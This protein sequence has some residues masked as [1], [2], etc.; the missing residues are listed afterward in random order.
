MLDAEDVGRRML[1]DCTGQAVK[2]VAEDMADSIAEDSAFVLRTN[3]S[4]VEKE[5]RSVHPVSIDLHMEE[6]GEDE[7]L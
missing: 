4:H 3:S 6:E 7:V 1:G 2:L 5:V